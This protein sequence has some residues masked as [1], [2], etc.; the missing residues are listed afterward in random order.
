MS[1]IAEL[2]LSSPELP[3]TESVSAVPE[4]RLQ[5]EQAIAEDPEQPILFLWASG[6]DFEEFE[7]ALESDVTI[8]NPALLEDAGE[9]RLY[10]VQISDRANIVM[11]PTDLAVGASRL[12]VTATARGIDIRMRFPDRDALGHFRDICDKR[13]ISLSLHTL[14]EGS[15]SSARGRYGLSAEQQRTLSRASESGYYRVPR[16]I[17]LDEL[18]DDLGISR[19]AASERLRRGT[20]V[21]IQNTLETIEIETAMYEN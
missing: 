12:A 9:R 7:T 4:M 14:Y 19:Q 17:G 1:L 10:R 2:R 11:Y 16:E 8:E 20:D 6:D 13:D 5:V 18:S 15:D 3:L 21:L